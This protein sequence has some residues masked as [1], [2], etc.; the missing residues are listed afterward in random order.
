MLRSVF[1]LS[2]F[3]LIIL[4]AMTGC[5]SQSLEAHTGR[6]P[7]KFVAEEVQWNNMENQVEDLMKKTNNLGAYKMTSVQIKL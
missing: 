2:I 6:S 4:M 5:S 3:S 1:V 7:A